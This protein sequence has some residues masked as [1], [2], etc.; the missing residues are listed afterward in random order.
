MSEKL[1]VIQ[2]AQRCRHLLSK[3]LYVNAG[4]SPGEEAVRHEDNF[5]CGRNQSTYGPDD[6]ICTDATC[7]NPARSCYEA[8]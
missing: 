4:L 6:Q 7:R 1:P 2:T 8:P 5:W 3:A